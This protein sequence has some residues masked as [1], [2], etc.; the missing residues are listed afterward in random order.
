MPQMRQGNCVPSVETRIRAV[1]F[2]F[3]FDGCFSAGAFVLFYFLLL[4]IALL[5]VLD[6]YYTYLFTGSLRHAVVIRLPVIFP[7][8]VTESKLVRFHCDETVLKVV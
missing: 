6:R 5:F 4:L 1:P 8:T 7:L 3:P 2:R